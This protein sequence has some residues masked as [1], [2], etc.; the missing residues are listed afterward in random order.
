MSDSDA[1]LFGGMGLVGA[2]IIYGLL[3]AL[4]ITMVLFIPSAVYMLRGLLIHNFG[5]FGG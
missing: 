2:L 1:A 4:I 3:I 5:M